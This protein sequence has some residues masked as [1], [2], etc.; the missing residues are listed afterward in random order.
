M[1]ESRAQ[2]KKDKLLVS[3]DLMRECWQR[4]QSIVKTEK[5]KYFSDIVTTNCHKP[6]VIFKIDNCILNV[7][8]STSLE[9]A[10]A[11]C[12]KSPLEHFSHLFHM[13]HL[14][15]CAPLLFLIVLSL[16]HFHF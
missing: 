11:I 7:P 2:W 3:F 15:L 5:N 12:E 9:A 1:Q 13:T 16:S 10:P 8:Q 4:Y 14:S 6:C